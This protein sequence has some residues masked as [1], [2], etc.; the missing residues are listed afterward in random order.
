MARGH[1][2]GNLC[3][4][5]RELPEGVTEIS[6]HPG[7]GDSAGSGYAAERYVETDTLCDPL[8]AAFLKEEEIAL[9]TF[10]NVHDRCAER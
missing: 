8:V 6:C 1:H 5:L 2:P 10:G 4:L 9:T 3:K 7:F